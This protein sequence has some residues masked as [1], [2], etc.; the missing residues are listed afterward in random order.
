MRK[1]YFIL[2]A[3]L[4]YAAFLLLA[5]PLRTLWPLPLANNPWTWFFGWAAIDAGVLL[6][7]W[8]G[9]L[10]L[11]RK[12]T[13]N[14]YGRPHFLITEGPFKVTR[15]PIY[16]ADTLLYMGVALLLADA[17]A[18]LFLPLVIFSISMGVIRHEERLLLQHFGEEYHHYMGKVRRWL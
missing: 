11:W 9:L 18:W 17:W 15:N 8:T 16:V 10:M 14:P 7:S 2:P 13:L 1:P 4:V 5:W 12:T 3:P 6:A